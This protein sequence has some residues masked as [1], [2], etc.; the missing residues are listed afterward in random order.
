MVRRG[1][2]NP[3]SYQRVVLAVGLSV[4]ACVLA[5]AWLGASPFTRLETTLLDWQFRLRGERPVTR[6][7]VIVAIDE[8]SLREVGRWPWSRDVQAELV[9]AIVK[10][11]PA[12]IGLDII[13]AEPQPVPSSRKTGMNGLGP[14]PAPDVALARALGRAERSVL[15]LPLLVPDSRTRYTDALVTT[16]APASMK[17]SE[18]ML[19]RQAAG[20][21]AFDP[22]H[23]AVALPIIPALAETASGI[24]HAY[25][26]PDIDGVTRRE[27]TALGFEDAYY[28]SFALELARL[29]LDIPRERVSLVLGE[30]IRLGRIFVPTDEK[31][32]MLI[33]YA[34]RER[35][36]PFVSATDV[37]RQRVAAGSFTGKVVLVGTAALG[38]YDQAITPFSANVPSVEKNATVVENII[39]QHMLHNTLWNGPL[40]LLLVLLFGITLTYG[41]QRLRAVQGT[42]L[43]ACALL[44]Y[45]GVAQYLFA[46]PGL[47]LPMGAPVLTIILVFVALTIVNVLARERQAGAI[48]AMFSSYV[49]PRIVEELVRSPEKARLGGYRRE[50]TM[51]FA[52]LAG[53]TR[54]SEQRPAEEVV[55][56]LNEYLAAMTEVVFRWNGTLDKF[57]GD[58]I[59]VFW[60]APIEQ[61]DHA[62][63]AVKCALHMRKR[64]EELQQRWKAEGKEPL[65]NGIGI[66]TGTVV[67]G[68]IGAEG[69]KMDYT[70]VGDQVN[71]AA[72]FQ[73]LTRKFGCPIV[74]T[75]HT[76]GRLKEL[77]QAEERSDN[78]G[79]IGHVSL[80]RLGTVTVKGSDRPLGA[81][82]VASLAREEAS[83]VDE[84]GPD[85]PCEMTEK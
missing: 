19:I 73:G 58:E 65:D 6:D 35:T 48:R 39:H 60:G 11:Q 14:A 83:R 22:Y 27:Y 3:Q 71:V 29:H 72:R 21:D 24:G 77:M 7:V 55:A 20:S 46:K 13:Y 63:L 18:F 45:A 51:L 78:Q 32:R 42:T 66:N 31:S 25:S 79:R 1:L 17:K 26:L 85:E 23:A 9:S 50:V 4:T 12:V 62:E 10:D 34:G 2:A 67:V 70:V 57:V 8:K 80:R 61:P 33:N 59:V 69:R 15:A 52:D 30:G 74:L 56:Q 81:Y 64:L 37:L 44:G 40:E 84:S 16:T 47:V 28:P 76:A 68:N 54:F 41:L 43:A 5:L 38:T 53:F 49:S 82:S 75:E 36:F